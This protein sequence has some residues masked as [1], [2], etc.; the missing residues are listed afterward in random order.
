M[1]TDKGIDSYGWCSCSTLMRGG[2]G[3]KRSVE[4]DEDNGDVGSFAIFD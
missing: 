2:K 1:E 3:R 4:D